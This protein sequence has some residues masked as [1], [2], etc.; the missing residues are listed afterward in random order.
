MPFSSDAQVLETSSGLVDVLRGAAS[1]PTQ[2]FRPAHAKGHL[3]TGTFTPTPTAS[4]LS[5]AHHFNHPSTPITLRFSSSTG[6]PSIPDTDS[7]GNPRGLAIRFHLPDKGGKRQHTDIVAHST[8]SFPTRTG[9]EFLEFLRAAGGPNAA[10]AVPEFLGRH[11]ETV[12]FLQEPKPSPMSFATEKYYG[13]N[14]FKFTSKEGKTTTLRYRVVPVAAPAYLE[15]AALAAK[16]PTY[17]F[18]ELAERLQSRPVEFKLVAQIAEEGDVTDNATVVWP[19]EREVVELGTLR[20]EKTLG[21]EES[22]AQQKR[23]IFDPI[24]RVEG[25]EASDDPLLEVRA[26]VYLI[27]GQQRRA[28]EDGGAVQG[29]TAEAVKTVT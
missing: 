7:N 14:A 20:V 16:S 8:P 23:I 19:E 3:L 27:S 17:L 25:V 10:D 4:T 15:A 5:S 9:A 18:D 11:P 2:E 24:P 1:Q 13:V 6:L 12:R 26:N 22:R 21:E 28:A 29:A